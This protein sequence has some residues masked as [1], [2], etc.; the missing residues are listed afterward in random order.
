MEKDKKNV[1]KE[2][3]KNK[4]KDEKMN[5]LEWKKEKR[6]L[7]SSTEEESKKQINE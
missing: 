1:E 7:Q 3:I 4:R 2:R 6:K 5:I